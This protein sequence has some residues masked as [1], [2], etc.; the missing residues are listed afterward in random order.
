[1]RIFR[2]RTDEF[3]PSNVDPQEALRRARD[4]ITSTGT[5]TDAHGRRRR[6]SPEAQERLAGSLDAAAAAQASGGDLPIWPTGIARFS[7]G[8]LEVTTGEG[9]RVAARDIEEIYVKAPRA[10]RFSLKVKYRAGLGWRKHGY[11][12]EAQHEAALHAL[13]SRVTAAAA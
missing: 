11:W 2:K 7:N 10:G 3:D 4:A 9:I 6:L 1:M 12:V 8:I 13:V 5:Y